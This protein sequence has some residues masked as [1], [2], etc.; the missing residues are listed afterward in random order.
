MITVTH[1]DIF[2]LLILAEGRSKLH[3]DDDELIRRIIHLIINKEEFLQVGFQSL[4][5]SITEG[6]QG[7]VQQ[8]ARMIIELAVQFDHL[9]EFHEKV[10]KA[11][12]ELKV[13][14]VKENRLVRTSVANLFI[15]DISLRVRDLDFRDLDLIF[16]QF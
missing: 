15:R 11:L 3:A 16:S 4:V 2:C 12:E 1:V 10:L 5:G 6:L 13:E 14:P 8:R 7:N 9:A